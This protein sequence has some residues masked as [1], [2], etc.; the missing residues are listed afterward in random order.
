MKRITVTVTVEED[1]AHNKCRW[2]KDDMIIAAMERVQSEALTVL[3]I[4]A[5]I[6][7]VRKL[8]A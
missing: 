8:G 3:R 4:D 1:Y 5:K 6:G 2:L 7:T